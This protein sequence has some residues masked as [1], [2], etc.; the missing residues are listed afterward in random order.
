MLSSEKEVEVAD[1][2]EYVGDH[3]KNHLEFDDL[4]IV[5]PLQV[6]YRDLPHLDVDLDI[7]MNLLD[8][9]LR[10]VRLTAVTP[11]HLLGD[12]GMGLQGTIKFFE[13]L[14]NIATVEVE[15]C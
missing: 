8:L 6:V 1:D 11:L 7:Q 14:T 13:H 9:F 12:M 3:T 10:E 2:L 5:G 15:T 4:E